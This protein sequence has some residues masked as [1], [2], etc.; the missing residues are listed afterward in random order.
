M[1]KAQAG[2]PHPFPDL[3]PEVSCNTASPLRVPET[4]N[5]RRTMNVSTD[6]YVEN[7]GYVAPFMDNE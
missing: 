1:T 2:R 6:G 4:G 5:E 7:E 3:H